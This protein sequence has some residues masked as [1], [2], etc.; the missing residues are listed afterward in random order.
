MDPWQRPMDYDYQAAAHQEE[1]L[2]RRWEE[3]VVKLESLLVKTKE[4]FKHEYQLIEEKRN[5]TH[6]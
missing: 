3:E 4:R 2:H 1:L 5:G 6:S